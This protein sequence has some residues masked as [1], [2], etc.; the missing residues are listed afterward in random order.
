MPSAKPPM[1]R[2]HRWAYHEAGH[3]ILAAQYKIEIQRVS[4]R[5]IP[6]KLNRSIFQTAADYC[7]L[8]IGHFVDDDL[9]LERYVS[10]LMGGCAA[11]ML[12]LE[13]HRGYK[14]RPSLQD[15][16]REHW[17]KSIWER[18]GIDLDK[19]YSLIVGWTYTSPADLWRYR[20]NLWRHTVLNLSYELAWEAV[21]EV[22]QRLLAG[23]VLDQTAV[24]ASL[25]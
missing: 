17:Y 11:D 6:G 9:R 12:A 19:A 5:Q 3:A 4:I 25:R 20:L 15:R 1:P 8:R 22:A 14:N 21:E 7:S 13:I 24:V 23:E 10:F 18:P 16:F 2:K